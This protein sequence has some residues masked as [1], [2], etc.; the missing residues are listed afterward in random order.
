MSGAGW[1]ARAPRPA[2]AQALWKSQA[3][4]S[5][6]LSTPKRLAQVARL[7]PRPSRRSWRPEIPPRRTSPRSRSNGAASGPRFRSHAGR[8]LRPFG[9]PRHRESAVVCQQP[10]VVGS[11]QFGG[12]RQSRPRGVGATIGTVALRSRGTERRRRQVRRLCSR[13]GR[14]TAGAALVA[15]HSPSAGDQDD[16][17]VALAIVRSAPARDQS[18]RAQR[19]TPAL[20]TGRLRERRWPTSL[21]PPRRACVGSGPASAGR[22]SLPLLVPSTATSSPLRSCAIP[23]E[24]AVSPTATSSA[25]VLLRCS[26]AAESGATRSLGHSASA[27]AG[28]ALSDNP[29][30]VRRAC[31]CSSSEAGAVSRLRGLPAAA[32]CAGQAS[33]G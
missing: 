16:R 15:N 17:G 19:R 5:R 6:H 2:L 11:T 10:P 12:R 24:A 30:I 31:P 28:L 33:S 4:T 9:E 7:L 25:P 20:A 22:R 1:R 3:R 32:L 14:S 21:S 13:P 27:R 18:S 8:P 29:A 23:G 26:S